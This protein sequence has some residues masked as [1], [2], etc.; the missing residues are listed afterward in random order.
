MASSETVSNEDDYE[1]E[2]EQDM[3]SREEETSAQSVINTMVNCSKEVKSESEVIHLLETVTKK[4]TTDLENELLDADMEMQTDG[5]NFIVLHIEDDHTSTSALNM[6]GDPAEDQEMEG[7]DPLVSSADCEGR[8]SCEYCNDVF[9]GQD[10]LKEH[11]AMVHKVRGG[12]R[13]RTKGVYPCPY[14]E[15]SYPYPS[16]LNEH[17]VR[18]THEKKFSCDICWR[19]FSRLGDMYK[20]R[21]THVGSPSLK[22]V[23]ER[24]LK[25]EYWCFECNKVFQ[26]PSKLKEHLP[27]HVKKFT[28]IITKEELDTFSKPISTSTSNETGDPVETQGV[29]GHFSEPISTSTSN[30]MGDPVETQAVPGHF[31]EPISASTSNK[32]GDPVETQAVPGHFSELISTSASKKSGDPAKTQK[33][34]VDY[35][36]VSYI[37]YEGRCF[38][39][40]CDEVLTGEEELKEH[41]FNVHKE[42]VAPLKRIKGV[43]PCPHCDRTYWFPSKLNEHLVS[44]TDVKKY[45]CDICLRGFSRIGDMFK[46][47]SRH[48]ALKRVQEL[49]GEY[50]CFECSKVFEWQSELQEHLRTHV[51]EKKNKKPYTCKCCK[52]TFH[53]RHT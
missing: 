32:T 40:H 17:L 49:K 16:K 18:H 7:D 11:R 4:E 50:R 25:G 43:Y 27:K 21:S 41:I 48:K 33:A 3:S 30:K 1:G 28:S 10:E 39:R 37:G 2:M 12:L 29:P 26:Y 52:Q 44:H 24:E 53:G 15:R 22:R 34:P 35:P 45:S 42:K 23:R 38:C 46:H 51:K 47:R 13:K 8:Y 31:S 9:N 36:L 20:H 6:V 14:C 5:M 19:G